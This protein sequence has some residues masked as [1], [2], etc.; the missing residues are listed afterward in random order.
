MAR[1]SMILPLMQPSAGQFEC[2]QDNF[3]PLAVIPLLR[4]ASMI[5]FLRRDNAL[6]STNRLRKV[7]IVLRNRA[8]LIACAPS[9]ACVTTGTL[10]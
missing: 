8:A 9:F 5:P 3:W 2:G 1:S 6:G 10:A 7:V 4:S